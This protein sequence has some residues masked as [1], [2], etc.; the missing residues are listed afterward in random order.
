MV[1]SVYLVKKHCHN[2]TFVTFNITTKEVER[3]KEDDEKCAYSKEIS[4]RENKEG[5]YGDNFQKV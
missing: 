4:R 1:V 5:T 2:K 3:E